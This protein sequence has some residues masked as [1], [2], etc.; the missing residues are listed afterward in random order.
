[1]ATRKVGT[2]SPWRQRLG[3][4]WCALAASLLPAVMWGQAAAPGG[5]EKTFDLLI[6][7][8]RVFDAKNHIDAVMDVG[9]KGGV[10]AQVAPH[11]DAAMATRVVD[12][13]GL[14]VTPGL[15][16]IHGHVYAGTGHKDVLAGDESVYPDGF[17]FRVGVTTIVDAG[18]SGWRTFEDFKSRVIDIS[19]TRVLADLNIVGA[20]M[21]EATLQSRQEDMDGDA[22]AAM[23]KK[24]PGVVVG[25]KVAHYAGPGW[26]PYDEAEKAAR[27]ANLFVMIDFG[28]SSPERPLLELMRDKL[29]PGDVYT[30]CY[31]GF[32]GEQDPTT[33]RASEAMLVARKR[34]I[35]CDVGHGSGSFPWAVAEPMVKA[36]YLPDS[37]STDLHF[38]SMNLGMKDMLNV[39]DKFLALGETTEQVFTQMT[40]TPAR[41]IKHEELGNL[42]P[43]SAG[44]VAV[45]RVQPGDF[46]FIDSKNVRYPGHQ[47]LVCEMTVRDGHVVYDL[48]GLNATPYVAPTFSKTPGA[49][50]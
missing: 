39:A 38:E 31:S 19:K 14:W 22:T 18:T 42:S 9:L 3:T 44:D 5:P 36:G 24:Y 41:E 12:A 16:D 23:A 46:G 25:V 32:R 15:I 10:I 27:A 45:F 35:F 7:H 30:H 37:I 20:G 6:A 50:P 47:K 33:G 48:N 17:T 21:Q 28:E 43:G 4:R 49:K 2:M 29:R 8:G 13:T 1:M 40:W 11:L 34:G 26:K